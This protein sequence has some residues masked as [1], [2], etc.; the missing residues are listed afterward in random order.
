M[1]SERGRGT[2]RALYEPLLRELRALGYVHAFA[3][4]T[5]P[6]DA[7]IALHRALGFVPVGV[8][9]K[10][11]FKQ[12]LWHDVQWWQLPLGELHRQPREPQPWSGA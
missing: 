1:E 2:G 11:G 12:D 8:F 5:L 9:R 7:S 6:N 3:G 10:V 4:I